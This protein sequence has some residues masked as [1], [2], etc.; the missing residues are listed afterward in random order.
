VNG[1]SVYRKHK[2]LFRVGGAFED[3]VLDLKMENGNIMYIP[4]GLNQ[5]E[6]LEIKGL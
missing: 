6:R 2:L 4:K 1:V 5:I 3:C